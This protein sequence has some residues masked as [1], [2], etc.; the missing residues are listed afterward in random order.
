MAKRQTTKTE[1]HK[2]V[3]IKS[4]EQFMKELDKR[5][6]IGAELLSRKITNHAELTNSRKD[7]NSWDDY[8]LELLK[9]SFD[10]PNNDYHRDYCYTGIMITTIG[11]Q[12]SFPELLNEHKS[13]INKQQGRLQ[14]IRSKVDLI[15]TIGLFFILSG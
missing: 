3:L 11:H 6:E 7:F 12:P 13:E 15:E 5:L 14:N 4:H 8:N 10:R 9:Q 2:D 1:V